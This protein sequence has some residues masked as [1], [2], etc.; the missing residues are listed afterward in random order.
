[1]NIATTLKNKLKG[2]PCK[3]KNNDTRVHIPEK[4]LFTYPDVSVVCGE[5]KYLNDDKTNLL[6]PTVIFEVQSPSTKSY[7]RNEKFELYKTILTLKEYV[8]VDSETIRV[9]V[10]QKQHNG[11]WIPFIYESLNETLTLKS[12]STELALKEIYEDVRLG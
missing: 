4:K 1:L 2:G 6:N 12:T 7:D 5:A 10:R 9:E 8:L 3:P 11:T